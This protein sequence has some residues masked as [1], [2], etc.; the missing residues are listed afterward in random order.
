[1]WLISIWRWSHDNCFRHKNKRTYFCSLLYLCSFVWKNVSKSDGFPCFHKEEYSHS[2]DDNS[3][4]P[5]EESCPV[6]SYI[7]DNGL[8]VARCKEPVPVQQWRQQGDDSCQRKDSLYDILS[9][10]SLITLFPSSSSSIVTFTA[11]PG[12]NS[13]TNSGYSIKQRAPL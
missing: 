2:N 5:I 8:C 4:Y 6:A 12:S 3:Q 11:F 9:G 10:H 13:S 1:M 7:S